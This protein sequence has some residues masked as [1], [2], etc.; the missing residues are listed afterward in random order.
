VKPSRRLRIVAV[1]ALLL[2][3]V[4]LVL[5]C[6]EG[7]TPNP[8]PCPRRGPTFRLALTAS[9]E[10]LPSDVEIVVEYGSNTERFDLELGNAGNQDVCCRALASASSKLGPVPCA[11]PDAGVPSLVTRVECELSTNGAARLFVHASGFD[12]MEQMLEAE[13]LEGEEWEHCDA[14]VTRDV[15]LDLSRRDAGL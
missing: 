7:T 13:R 1:S 8:E 10:E 4:P 15:F 5:G 9:G 11:A 3:V 6:S 12:D 2:A 14:L